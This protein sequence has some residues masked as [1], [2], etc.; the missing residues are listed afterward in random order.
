M[1]DLRFVSLEYLATTSSSGCFTL[2][3][4]QKG[5]QSVEAKRNWSLTPKFVLT[6]ADCIQIQWQECISALI[7][8]FMTTYSWLLHNTHY[9]LNLLTFAKFAFLFPALAVKGDEA[10]AV[11]ESGSLHV[12]D[13][14]VGGSGASKYSHS[15]AAPSS[16]PK[17]SLA[18][19]DSFSITSV[20]YLRPMELLTANSSGQ[21]KLWDLR[22]LG[23][24]TK[25]QSQ[26]SNSSS[27]P[28][29]ILSINGERVGVQ[30]LAQHPTQPHLV[31][32]GGDDGLL[33]IWDLRMEKTP[34]TL[35]Q[36]HDSPIWDVSFHP[37]HPDHLFTCS[38]DGK[39]L[40]WDASTGGDGKRE[41]SNKMHFN[42]P[43]N[44]R[45]GP[46]SMGASTLGGGASQSPWITSGVG[47]EK[48]SNVVTSSL[49]PTYFNMPVNSIDIESDILLCGTD[50]EAVFTARNLNIH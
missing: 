41:K 20:I 45:M 40:H 39:V 14:G 5:N 49:L 22:L 11:G 4:H 30:S 16:S 47:V 19:A 21:L 27:S 34:A 7:T 15:S 48:K 13:L 28:S 36:G 46:L 29:K 44:S 35:L 43:S 32:A 42:S 33:T 6:G 38:D 24:S 9:C 26:H 18:A 23:S 2:F 31:A 1:T 17:L 25:Q 8:D 37:S 50:A 10:V 12:L 3:E